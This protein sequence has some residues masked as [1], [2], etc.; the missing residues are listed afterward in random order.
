LT[1]KTDKLEITVSTH[2]EYQRVLE[3]L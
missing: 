3:P 1:F 2:V